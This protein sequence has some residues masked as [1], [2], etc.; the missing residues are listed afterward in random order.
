[1]LNWHQGWL[2]ADNQLM[3]WKPALKSGVD[4]RALPLTP[5]EGFVASR[6]DGLLDLHQLSLVTGLSEERVTAAV[7]R[8]VELAAAEPEGGAVAPSPGEDEEKDPAEPDSYGTHRGLYERTLH[9]LPLQERIARA[10]S[11]REPE[12]SALCF[13][14]LPEV[15]QSVLNNPSVGLTHARLIAAHHR[16]AA[17]LEALLSRAA[18]AA[19]TGVRRFILKNPQLQPAHVRRL[20]GASRLLQQFKIVISREVTEQVHRTA[21]ELLRSRFASAPADE[22][23]ELIL[24]TEGRCL[25]S[26]AGLTFDGKTTAL[27]C[28]RTYGSTM[29]VQ[30][31]ARFAAT[32]PVLVAHLLK[33]ELVRR[34]PSLRTLLERHANAPSK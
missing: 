8:L 11:A 18:F 7:A 2:L 30:N 20:F 27:L 31:L 3:S 25:P 34:S 6:M 15:V 22:R 4:L 13:D 10:Q 21:R 32:P 16:T 24:K 19:D 17:G 33:Q 26:L 5:E 23:V 29:L 28:G 12:L 1:L 9:P 14:P